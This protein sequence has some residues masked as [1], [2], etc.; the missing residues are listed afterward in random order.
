MGILEAVENSSI[1][2]R[3]N[4]DV[5]RLPLRSLA[6]AGL[7]GKKAET[8]KPVK[9]LHRSRGLTRDKRLWKRQCR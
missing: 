2:N 1:G 6:G 9:R 5:F 8:E 7:E 3:Q 4:K